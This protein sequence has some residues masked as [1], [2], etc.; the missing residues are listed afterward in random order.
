MPTK[1]L[2]IGLGLIAGLCSG[3]VLAQARQSTET[4]PIDPRLA[5]KLDGSQEGKQQGE[6][7]TE[8]LKRISRNSGVAHLVD[9][10]FSEEP[11]VA[12][13]ATMGLERLQRTLAATYQLTWKASRD[14]APS[15]LLQMS[16]ADQQVRANARSGAELRGRQGMNAR[17]DQVRRLAFLPKDR[18][19]QVANEGDKQARSFLHPRTGAMAKLVF[20][21]P[22]HL[23]QQMQQGKAPVVPV[24]SLP[25][26][27]QELAKQA[28]G[29]T[30]VTT[31]NGEDYNVA[32]LVASQGQVR[33]Q[34]GGTWDR[35]TVWGS[36]RYGSH[37]NDF[38]VLYFEGGVRQPPEDRRKQAAAT[39][40]KPPG[41][42]TFREKVTLRDIP[43]P[44]FYEPGE[45]PKS[46]RPLLEYL[47]QLAAQ[48]ELP[49]VANC[50]YKGREQD[51]EGTWLRQQWWLASD[52]VDRPLTEALDL[53]CADFEYEWRFREGVLILR[54]KRWYQDR[55]DRAYVYP[56]KK[57]P[58]APR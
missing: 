43:R 15:Y 49:I 47:Q 34:R 20:Q 19:Q 10:P 41:N 27:L 48:T 55:T 37:G 28:A 13:N 21:L 22:A 11:V 25:A 36:L 24:A 8:Y 42:A 46:A 4:R 2:L 1:P 45:R 26:D 30:R 18:L 9:G 29:T 44:G 33:L 16:K 58:E 38:N 7:L 5:Q 52:I 35:P 39:P 31:S 56:P 32:D 6:L 51:K 57:I 54:P 53:L 17:L 40:T 14:N 12:L 23:W 50:E 3:A